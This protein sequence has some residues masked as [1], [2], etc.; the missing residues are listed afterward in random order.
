MRSAFVVLAAGTPP[1][2]AKPQAIFVVSAEQ[3]ES[4]A[5]TRAQ[6]Y[7]DAHFPTS[8]VQPATVESYSTGVVITS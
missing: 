8:V 4:A 3:G 5:Q 7:R 1:D 2:S 6:T